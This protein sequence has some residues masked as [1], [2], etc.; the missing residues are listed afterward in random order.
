MMVSTLALNGGTPFISQPHPPAWPQY[1][2]RT[3][4][5]VAEMV[6]RGEVHYEDRHP[7][8]EALSNHFCQLTGM[9]H[10]LAVNSASTGLLLG[11]LAM[12]FGPGDEV[13]CSPLSYYITATALLAVG[14]TPV[15]CDVEPDTGNIDPARIA[16]RVTPRTKGVVV[17]HLWGHPASML[18]IMAQASRHNLAVIEDAS[19]AHGATLDGRAVGSF[20]D[21]GVFSLG[22][23]KQISGGAAGI[24][25]SRDRSVHER[26][27]VMGHHPGLLEE[28]IR[29]PA[30]QTFVQT[31]LGLN[32]RPGLI[33]AAL[34]LSHLE[35]LPDL[36]RIR[37]RNFNALNAALSGL[38]DLDPMQTRPGATRGGWFG[39]KLMASPDFLQRINLD[40]FVAAVRAEGAKMRREGVVPIHTTQTFAS[41]HRPPLGPWAHR[42]DGFPAVCGDAC[43]NAIALHGRLLTLAAKYFHDDAPDLVAAYAGAIRKVLEHSDTLVKTHST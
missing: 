38:G 37:A 29:D 27:M 34:A 25:V 19:H 35:R 20:G 16:E 28:E 36:L 39:Y 23:R 4:G 8:I 31:G 10:A 22:T 12:G 30:L 33:A 42:E 13:L 41:G 2:E 5:L 40:R 26:M 24:A 21:V 11:Y 17:T 18:D 32:A 1:D 3:V 7:I 6:A 43:P 14:A 9:P 15:F